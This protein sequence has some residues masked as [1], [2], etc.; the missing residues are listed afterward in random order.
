MTT[1]IH[2][3]I[4]EGL[5]GENE[6]TYSRL[7]SQLVSVS[8]FT[9]TFKLVLYHVSVP[10]NWLNLLLYSMVESKKLCIY[11]WHPVCWTSA[12]HRDFK[13]KLRHYSECEFFG[14]TIYGG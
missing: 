10:V 2:N 8:Y 5:I 4:E 7:N 3:L 1:K 12:K 13:L 11:A 6:E 9:L 14:E